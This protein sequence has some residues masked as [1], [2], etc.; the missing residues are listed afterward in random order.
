MNY[1]LDVLFL[2][3]FLFYCFRIPNIRS[4]FTLNMADR[5]PSNVDSST[6]TKNDLEPLLQPNIITAFIS[7]L[8]V[9]NVNKNLLLGFTIGGLAGVYLQQTFPNQFPNVKQYWRE[10]KDKWRDFSNSKR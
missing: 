2:L 10:L 5:V 4:R 3:H 7:G 6:N 9:A 8:L 1:C